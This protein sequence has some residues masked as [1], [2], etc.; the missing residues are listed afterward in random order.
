MAAFIS[1]LFRGRVQQGPPIRA[2]TLL[3]GYETLE[4]VGE[5]FYQAALW[6]IVG[7]FT[8]ERVREPCRAVLVP[9]PTNPHDANA[10]QVIVAGQLVGHL[11]RQDAAAY[12][13]GLSR[14]M[15]SC[16]TRYIA[17]D[18]AIVGG[19][20]RHDGIGYLGVFLDHDPADFGIAAHYTTG[21]N[22]R[23]GLNQAIATDLGDDSYDLSW[24][25]TLGSD[26]QAAAEQVRVLLD[27]E[28][29]PIDR[30]YMFCELESRHYHRRSG[31]AR[32]VRRS[33]RATPRRDDRD[34]AGTC[35]QVQVRARDRDVP[36][37]GNPL[38]EGEGMGG[39]AR[40][41]ATWS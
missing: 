31:R 27:S 29:E 41:G 28:R 19:G 36:P 7:G 13:P 38:A 11:S 32:E 18:G 40:M 14:L 17:L 25:T 35:R 23:T 34:P 15:A 21:G 16:E 5:S 33:V 2:A 37:G 20:Q 30:H 12:L 39:R 22:L 8:R 26:D 6:Q 24:L 9:E 4:V 10:V 3:R 1:R